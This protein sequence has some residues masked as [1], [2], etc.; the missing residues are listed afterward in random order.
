MFM[1]GLCICCLVIDSEFNSTIKN[2]SYDI[3]NFMDLIKPYVKAYK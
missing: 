2:K 3:V 1:T